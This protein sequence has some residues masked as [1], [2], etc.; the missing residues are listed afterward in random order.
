M[1]GQTEKLIQII[2]AGRRC[3]NVIVNIDRKLGMPVPV[4]QGQIMNRPEFLIIL[5]TTLDQ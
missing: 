5:Y 4:L 1:V 3:C 2:V